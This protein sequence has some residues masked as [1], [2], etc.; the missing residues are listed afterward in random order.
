MKSSLDKAIADERMDDPWDEWDVS[1]KTI[2][3][4]GIAFALEFIHGRHFIH[5]DL[6]MQNVLV[7][8]DLEPVIGDFSLTRAWGIGATDDVGDLTMMVGTLLHMAPEN[9]A[10]GGTAYDLSIDIYTDAVL[11]YFFWGNSNCYELDD[12]RK[13]VHSKADHLKRIGTGARFARVDGIPDNYWELITRGWDMCPAK[14][15]SA[16]VL[17][18]GIIANPDAW[19]LPGTDRDKVIAYIKRWKNI[20]LSKTPEG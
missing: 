7:N 3:A 13:V 4:I 5:R 1:T 10:A 18:D 15:P 14:R 8:E 20:V 2:Y 17:V 12:T 19:L 11:L 6:K 16:Q 9:F